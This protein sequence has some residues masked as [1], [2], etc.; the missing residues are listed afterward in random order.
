MDPAGFSDVIRN[1]QI[2]PPIFIEPVALILPWVELVS[3]I[4]LILNRW[5]RGAALVVALLM[6][7][8]MTA[9]GI[10]MVRGVDIS[11]GCF[12][13]NQ[14]ATA[15]MWYYMI[16]D[17]L[18]LLMAAAILLYHHPRSYSQAPG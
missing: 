1:Y 2:L 4:S 7:I 9:L 12:T 8:F 16:R 6:M 11:C 10:N 5:T 13:L 17:I 3:G 15:S 18:L 14:E